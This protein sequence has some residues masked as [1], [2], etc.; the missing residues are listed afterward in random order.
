MINESTQIYLTFVLGVVLALIWGVREVRG[1]YEY[2]S[3]VESYWELSDKSSTLVQKSTYLDQ[4]VAALQKPDAFA[5][6]DAL[7][8]KTPNNSYAQNMVAL[9]SLQ[10]RMHEIQKMDASSFAYQTAIQ[11]ITAQEQGQ[12]HEMTSTFEGCWFLRNHVTLWGWI[13]FVMWGVIFCIVVV[14]GVAIAST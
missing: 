12:A 4:Y 6:Y 2:D 10:G 13:D 14:G 5:D 3:T 1:A 11:Q 8:Y 7:I 9:L